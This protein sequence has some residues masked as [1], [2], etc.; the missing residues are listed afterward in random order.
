MKNALKKLC[1]CFTRV[2]FFHSR[3]TSFSTFLLGVSAILYTNYFV[4]AAVY[5]FSYS[6]EL[7]MYYGCEDDIEIGNMSGSPSSNV[8]SSSITNDEF[9]S[10]SNESPLL[11]EYYDFLS[12]KVS[13]DGYFLIDLDMIPQPDFEEVE[14]P[15]PGFSKKASNLKATD[16]VGDKIESNDELIVAGNE[17]VLRSSIDESLIKIPGQNSQDGISS[18]TMTFLS[19]KGFFANVMKALSSER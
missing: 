19:P 18:S 4:Y 15:I 11:K 8:N 10:Y 9:P 7:N 14:T 2:K 5:P 13:N 1:T 6:F 3:M 16:L 17:I 12:A